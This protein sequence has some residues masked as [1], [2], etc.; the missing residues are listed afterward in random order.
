MKKEGRATGGA[1]EGNISS[2]LA[3]SI[4]NYYNYN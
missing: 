3:C 4:S 2:T 1:G